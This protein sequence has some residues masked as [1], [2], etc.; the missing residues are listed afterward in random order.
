MLQFLK[1]ADKFLLL[2]INGFHSP[3]LDELMWQLSESWH[4]YLIVALAA[5]FIY[6]HYSLKKG[7]EF[8]V[9][10]ALIIACCDLS[11]NFMKHQVKRYRP[12]HNTDIKPQV[13]LVN[14]YSGGKFGF[15]SGHAANITGLTVFMFLIFRRFKFKYFNL[16]F[17]YAALVGYSRMYL[18]V[19]YPSDIVFGALDGI[20]FG[21]LGYHLINK[22][23]F[24]LDDEKGF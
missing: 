17:I 23:L 16:I 20:M 11:S 7:I 22:F 4:T 10:C 15:F 5:I 12:S 21:T 8:L 9:A 13:R 24:K 3:L 2:K 6:K 19:H 14:N 1:D 18:G